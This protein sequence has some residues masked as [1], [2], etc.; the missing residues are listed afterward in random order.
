[1][2]IGRIQSGKHR[3]H[4]WILFQLDYLENR[5]QYYTK[6]AINIRLKSKNSLIEELKTMLKNQ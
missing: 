4:E 2:L 5:H 6:S 1:M 3:D